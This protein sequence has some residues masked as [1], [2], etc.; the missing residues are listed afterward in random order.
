MKTLI[1]GVIKDAYYDMLF[2]DDFLDPDYKYSVKLTNRGEI[3]STACW[4]FRDKKHVIF[5][6]EKILDK[7]GKKRKDVEHYIASYLYHEVAH[8]LWTEKDLRSIDDALKAKDIPFRVHN[9]FEDARIEH[10]MRE[11]ASRKF[12]WKEFEPLDGDNSDPLNKFFILIQGEYAA[13]TKTTKSR[14]QKRYDIEQK[15]IDYY[16]ETI[17]AKDSWEVIDVIQ[18]WIED[19]PLPPKPDLNDLLNQMGFGETEDLSASLQMQQDESIADI[20]DAESESVLGKGDDDRMPGGEADCTERDGSEHDLEHTS[21]DFSSSYSRA[22]TKIDKSAVNRLT[23]VIED[24][25]KSKSRK[26]P[27]RKPSKR[28]NMKAIFTDSEYIFRRKEITE[29]ARKKF[30]FV[31]DCSGSMW[32]RYMDGSATI[33]A[34]F[35][36]LA[37]KGLCEGKVVLSSSYGYQTLVLPLRDSTIESHF[38]PNGDEGFKKT[39]D[40]VGDVLSQADINFVLTDGDIVDGPLNKKTLQAKGIK[41]FGLYVGPSGRCNLLRWFDRGIA[42]ENLS[43]LADEIVRSVLTRPL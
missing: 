36:R 23:P 27:T 18:R 10:L 21:R 29:R 22:E 4:S 15:I 2:M 43:E 8:S 9:L 12:R 30:N 26:T 17:A 33:V 5:V 28:L 40:A 31:V 32:G 19:Y 13:A 35:S 3:A 24:I 37:Q 1:K 20:L 34:I 25:F 11:K 42:K 14:M 39:F 6:G 41:T 38:I 7:V 16:L